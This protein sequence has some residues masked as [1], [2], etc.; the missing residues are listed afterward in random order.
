MQEVHYISSDI[1]D[2]QSVKDILD[3]NKMLALSVEATLSINKARAYLVEKIKEDDTPIYGINT[4][5]ALYVM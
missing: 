1:L 2:L 4:G 3:S 5:F